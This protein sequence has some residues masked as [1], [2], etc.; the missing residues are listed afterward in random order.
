MFQIHDTSKIHTDSFSS[1]VHTLS[2]N[3]T[4]VV[5]H[6]MLT[7][8]IKIVV[9]YKHDTSQF[10]HLLIITILVKKKKSIFSEQ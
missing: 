7:Y 5:K 6:K 3:V 4:I 8:D 9:K 1:F 2:L 10:Y